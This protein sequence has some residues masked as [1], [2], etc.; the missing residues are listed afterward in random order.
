MSEEAEVDEGGRIKSI[1]YFYGSIEAS[2][3]SITID[4]FPKG[5]KVSD[6]M[7]GQWALEQIE[8]AARTL[9][10]MPFIEPIKKYPSFKPYHIT[11]AGRLKQM[12]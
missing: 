4:E 3:R 11:R 12:R 7:K 6:E 10:V 2:I 1:E 9:G 5:K 8:N